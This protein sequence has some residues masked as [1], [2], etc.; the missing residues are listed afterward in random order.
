MSRVGAAAGVRWGNQVVQ[1]SQPVREV[2]LRL[3]G[4]VRSRTS[5]IPFA[6]MAITLVVAGLAGLI[7]LRPVLEGQAFKIAELEQTVIALEAER[8]SL[9]STVNSLQSP[10]S[11]AERALAEGM[12]PNSSPVFLR[13][14]DRRVI[15]NAAPAR[16]GTNV[17][18][19]D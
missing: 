5:K 15:G 12:V 17:R 9:Q 14:S 19:A 4:P 10:G 7:G 11:I 13:L 1:R 6:T 16:P 8:S 18:R 2:G 3:V